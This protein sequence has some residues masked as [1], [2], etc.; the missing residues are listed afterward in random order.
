[1]MEI[2]IKVT[3]C[4]LVIF[5]F[6]AVKS[7]CSEQHQTDGMFNI[8]CDPKCV[9]DCQNESLEMVV[10]EARKRKISDLE[11]SIKIRQ[12]QLDTTLNFTN[13]SSLTISGEPGLTN[14]VCTYGGTGNATRAGIVLSGINGRVLL[15]NLNLSFCGL[16]IDS[17]FG[18]DS[19]KFYSALTISHCKNVE[20]DKVIIM[21]SKGL[22]LVM[23]NTQG[24]HVTI[25][26]AIFEGNEMPK[27][28]EDQVYGGGGAY[29]LLDHSTEDQS[30]STTFLFRNCSFVRNT[31]HTKH[32][33]FI[34]ILR[35]GYGRGGGVYVYVSSGLR[36]VHISFSDCKF[37]GNHAFIGGGLSVNI[38][39]QDSRIT[40]NITV[41]ITDTLF[42]WNGHDRN[43]SDNYAGLGGGIH[44]AFNTLESSGGISD[45]HFLL[46]NVS[47]KNNYADL[48][49]AVFYHSY[50]GR[51]DTS[52]HV[53]SMLFDNCTFTHNG[54][55]MGSA[56]AMM[57]Y[58]FQ[59]LSSGFIIIPKFQ[60][61]SFSSNSVYV[62]RSLDTH[63]QRI[64]GI[65]TIYTSFHDIHFEGDNTF[66]SN[67]GSAI[68]AVNGIV[69]LTNS[70]MNFSN[71]SG[72]QGGAIG[73]I[74]SSIVILGPKRYEFLYNT[75][76]YQGGAIYVALT[77]SIDFVSSRSCFFQYH[78]TVLNRKW[79]S[80]VTF[81]GNRAKD[82]TAGHA[83]YATSIRPCQVIKHSYVNQ[84]ET[85]VNVSETFD[86]KGFEFDN[87]V[88]RQ[89]QIATDGAL[90][91]STKPSPLLIIPGQ[92]YDHGV[93]ITDDLG[94]RVKASFRV[95]MNKHNEGGIMLE[96][97]W[98]TSA[99]I[100]EKIQLQGVPNQNTSL[101]LHTVSPR[102]NYIMLNITLLECPPG[103]TF[104]NDSSK[105]VCDASSYVSIIR[106]DLDTFHSH[107]LPGFW[108]GLVKTLNKS[109]LVTC[110]CPFCDYGKR[111]VS[112]ISDSKFEV[113]LLQNYSDLNKA[114]C[115]DRRT[116]IVCGKC[117]DG[118]TVHFHSPDFV[119]KP[120]EPIGCK[121]GWL[122]YI[123]SE[124]VPV[125]VVFITVLVLNISFTSGA[126]NGFILFSQLLDMF[127]I[128]ASGIISYPE[129]VR[130]TIKGWIQRYRFIYGFFN[131]DFFNSESISFCLWKGASALDML[132]L[133]YV[134]I[135]YTLLLIVSVIW[136]MN[137]CG[138]KCCG[139]FCRITTIR[140]SVVHG[141]STFLVICY[142]QC[143]KVSLY[144]LIPIWLERS[145]FKPRARVW[146][147]SELLYFSKEHLPYAL[148]AIFCLLTI[149]LLPPAM[150][151]TY[152]LGNKVMMFLGCEDIKFVNLL[153]QKLSISRNLKPLLDS[154]QGCFKD[155]LRFFTGLYF[156]YRWIIPFVHVTADGFGIYYCTLSGVLLL[157]LVL[158]TICQPYIQRAHNIIDTLLFSNL[159]LINLLS[160]FN[161]YTQWRILRTSGIS[162]SPVIIQLVLIYLPLIVMGG[163]I[164]VMFL[165]KIAQ[166]RYCVLLDRI[167]AIFAETR[168]NTLRELIKSLSTLDKDPSTEEYIH[169]RLMDEGEQNYRNTH[170]YHA[171]GERMGSTLL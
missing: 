59:K 14:I 45:T 114:V 30:E 4:L 10:E 17:K 135:L 2:W 154:I 74:G 23:D 79:N 124:L 73:L 138:G 18:R 49:G 34:Y 11:I 105:C 116:G 119:C 164:L 3:T 165:K 41:E 122:F 150:L 143:V 7:S 88:N 95:S 106:C 61:C 115:G 168:A 38:S 96:S 148:P 62:K 92:K 21:R 118:Y 100:G 152:P 47:F 54:A 91:R 48:G 102:P 132:A 161:Y 167:T 27:D 76:L 53:N 87:D 78:S 156:L 98:S 117:R 82:E 1:M 81:V 121:M 147:N 171:N 104:N 8:T 43:N 110:R 166:L 71:N 37:I 159:I 90:L 128:D 16:K 63:T 68:H 101:Y 108:I 26:S 56:V 153:S 39:G 69:N 13:L 36:N 24:G 55:H 97:T 103:F 107:L 58:Q 42:Q 46:Q 9:T 85:L 12:L 86:I 33:E 163:Y 139:K 129:S 127:N 141:I 50:C 130:N 65:G 134:T 112:N 20:F 144:L 99:Y 162:V 125:T 57:P 94:H 155:N 75:A 109:E 142:A 19:S 158:H 6:L 89:P 35:S 83:I 51:Q 169:D 133:K 31:A 28:A 64:G 157:I 44:L 25:T 151:L 146:L 84:T 77:D 32:Y 67:Q 22:G 80:S 160:F 137:K 5:L 111:I 145:G 66:H 15:Q 123:L 113:I 120:A 29:I 40:Q 52:N 131:L 136:I 72:I 126:V 60:D 149:G 93:V 140:T 70:D 170:K